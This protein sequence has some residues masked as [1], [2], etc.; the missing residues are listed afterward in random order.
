MATAMPDRPVYF[1]Q[2]L[3]PAAFGRRKQVA[4]YFLQNPGVIVGETYELTAEEHT[5]TCEVVDIRQ[6]S[7]ASLLYDYA[8][9]E[10]IGRPATEPE[11]FINERFP[12]SLRKY[13]G[14]RLQGPVLTRIE[15]RY[16]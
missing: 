15:W 4:A 2:A 7:F 14:N 10:R 13:Y 12:G 9:M 8:E 1:S 3:N 5:A 16:L 6:A 11:E